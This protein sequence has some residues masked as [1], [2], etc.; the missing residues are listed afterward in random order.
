MAGNVVKMTV[1]PMQSAVCDVSHLTSDLGVYCWWGPTGILWQREKR[2]NLIWL[3]SP[4]MSWF[5]TVANDFVNFYY[6]ALDGDRVQLQ[7]VYVS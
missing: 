3:T 7:N 4:E 1:R 2:A 6:P 5:E